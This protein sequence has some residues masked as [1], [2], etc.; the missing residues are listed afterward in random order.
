ME[1]SGNDGRVWI[2][3]TSWFGNGICCN[4]F[5]YSNL[6]VFVLNF[7]S[8]V[9]ST[10]FISFWSS[11]IWFSNSQRTWSSSRY[12]ANPQKKKKKSMI[13]VAG[14]AIFW[15]GPNTLTLKHNLIFVHFFLFF[16]LSMNTSP[17]KSW[18]TKLPRM[19]LL[20]S[21]SRLDSQKEN[22]EGLLR[23]RCGWHS[24]DPFG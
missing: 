4:S 22:G 18:T 14:V 24:G 9:I 11:W 1:F 16:S 5:R 21:W 12:W 2:I 10:I 3:Y 20:W 17:S 8:V 23:R 7:R 6:V 15:G 13:R 19:R